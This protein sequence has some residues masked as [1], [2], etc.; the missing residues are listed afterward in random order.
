MAFRRLSEREK[1]ARLRRREQQERREQD[2]MVE[3]ALG[4]EYAEREQQEIDDAA[5]GRD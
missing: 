5:D 3:I 1:L 4:N 2:R